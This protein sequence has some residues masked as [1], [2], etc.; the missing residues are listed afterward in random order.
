M[1]LSHAACAAAKQCPVAVFPVPRSEIGGRTGGIRGNRPGQRARWFLYLGNHRI[2]SA[3]VES[4]KHPVC[5]SGFPKLTATSSDGAKGLES[6]HT[7][8]PWMHHHIHELQ[9]ELHLSMYQAVFRLGIH[10]ISMNMIFHSRCNF[11]SLSYLRRGRRNILC[12]AGRNAPAPRHA[13]G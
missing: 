10:H 12:T 2:K 6:V 9:R 1:D 3:G 11:L 13:G 5:G 4:L 8:F 7:R